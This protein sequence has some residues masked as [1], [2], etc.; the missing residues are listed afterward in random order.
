VQG[1]VGANGATG[2]AGVTGIQAI[3]GATGVIGIT[4]DSFAGMIESVSNKTYVLDS[5]APSGYTIN[6]L[7]ILSGSGTVTVDIYNGAAGVSGLFNISV[8]TGRNTVTATGNNTISAGG[9]MT[10][11]ARSNASAANMEFTLKIT[12]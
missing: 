8:T 3:Q 5:Y 10:M 9:R 11:V 1:L 6:S 12:R 7:S 4:I 2:V